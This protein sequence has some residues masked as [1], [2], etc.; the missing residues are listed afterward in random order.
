[1]Q[2]R[3]ARALALALLVGLLPGMKCLLSTSVAAEAFNSGVI[4]SSGGDPFRR[5]E[6]MVREMVT[7]RITEELTDGYFGMGAPGVADAGVEHHVARWLGE[8]AKH[9]SCFC[10]LVLDVADED[11]AGIDV[12]CSSPTHPDEGKCR[13]DSPDS[14]TNILA[15]VEQ[16]VIAGEGWSAPFD[17]AD[18]VC[19]PA[20]DA[21]LVNVG[22]DRRPERRQVRNPTVTTRFV[23]YLRFR[24]AIE[25]AVREVAALLVEGFATKEAI[26]AASVDAFTEASR[27]MAERRWARHLDRKVIGIVSKGGAA[28]G[29]FSAGAIWAVIVLSETRSTTSSA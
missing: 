29:V 27:Y 15:S 26:L 11:L 17:D 8:A 21:P 23:D 12:D 2:E 22:S 25:R 3:I 9:P 5:R 13:L 19:A 1:V 24:T 7:I 18:R 20:E 10:E 14:R 6:D 16:W 28:T 4:D